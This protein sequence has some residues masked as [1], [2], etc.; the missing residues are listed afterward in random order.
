MNALKKEVITVP[1]GKL[2]M[3]SEEDPKI[4][5]GLIK[6][7]N[8]LYKRTGAIE[9]R[10]GDEQ[11][12]SS[13]AEDKM[14]L[15]DGTPMLYDEYGKIFSDDKLITLNER[16]GFMDIETIGVAHSR[17]DI[18]YYVDI[19]EAE[20]VYVVAYTVSDPSSATPYSVLLESFD[21]NTG[22]RLD[23]STL[24]A[25]Q[26]VPYM[27]K[28]LALPASTPILC[29]YF[30]DPDD[31]RYLQNVTINV[32]TGVISSATRCSG[33]RQL[34]TDCLNSW[35][36]CT[37]PRTVIGTPYAAV[38]YREQGNSGS[39]V[40]TMVS[41]GST[42]S[43]VATSNTQ[44]NGGSVIS[45]GLNTADDTGYLL[46]QAELIG[47]TTTEIYAVRGRYFGTFDITGAQVDTYSENPGDTTYSLSAAEKDST[48]YHIFIERLRQ[49]SSIPSIRKN[50]FYS[51]SGTG[52]ALY[53]GTANEFKYRAAFGAKPFTF[54][55]GR[56]IVPIW[57]RAWGITTSALYHMFWVDSDSGSVIGKSLLGECRRDPD[58][59]LYMLSNTTETATDTFTTV[60][61]KLIQD[62]NSEDNRDIYQ[63]VRMDAK[64]ETGA[65][66]ATDTHDYTFLA[67]SCPYLVDGNSITEQGF[68]MY[69][70][71][72]A[73]QAASG[74]SGMDVGTYRYKLVYEWVDS[75]GNLHES[76]P[77][78]DY[79][80]VTLAGANTY[81]IVTMPTLHFTRKEGILIAIYRTT[82]SGSTYYRVAGV[83]M[84][85]NNDYTVY[86]D[87][88]NDS[89]IT[90]L[91]TLYTGNGEV[92]NIQP[93]PHRVSAVWQR[94]HFHVDREH[95]DSWIF[96]SKEF[97]QGF[98]PRDTD[99][100][101]LE[102]DPAGGRITALSYLIDKLIIFKE[103]RIYVTEGKGYTDTGGG[104]NFY[105]PYLISPSV[106]CIDQR[107]IVRTPSGVMFQ[108]QDGIWLLDLS[109]RLTPL[110]Q[111]VQEYLEGTSIVGTAKD[112]SRHLV[113]FFSDGYDMTY[114]WLRNKWS[115][116]SD[117]EAIAAISTDDEAYWITSDGYLNRD[118][119]EEHTLTSIHKINTLSF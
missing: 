28:V 49:S 74:S 69:P 10:T 16:A 20:D 105:T 12:L 21:K 41:G 77:S 38:A 51:A 9:K 39:N 118:R 112:N 42:V 25:D 4:H 99:L 75:H 3:D 83:P 34:S 29:C 15:Y 94:R 60:G 17:R 13:I 11:L 87:Y 86:N 2:G 47:G 113:Q 63:I 22:T 43:Y 80:E 101:L 79:G 66:S 37:I 32:E 35:D 109:L 26:T 119:S 7:K 40:I 23:S 76:S 18:F 114:D 102:C 64:L 30:F 68:L 72:F 91:K 57:A 1:I 62:D 73:L 115:I 65:L 88:N 53:G 103:D 70:E 50:V 78:P 8:G 100:F 31:S 14:A 44:F 27:A 36:A 67:N 97:T 59:N 24:I 33:N 108:A 81:A 56:I 58:F 90:D 48:H 93:R 98:G 19:A 104:Y 107:S 52:T 54:S 110:G 55:D 95:E 46:V 45:L 5:Q 61:I 92:E 85:T 117:R 116:W 89:N 71:P 106:G 111:P 6:V 82:E 96:Y 84:T